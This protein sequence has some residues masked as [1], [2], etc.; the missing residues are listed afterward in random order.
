MCWCVG[1]GDGAEVQ[2]WSGQQ[3]LHRG[4]SYPAAPA[5][6]DDAQGPRVCVLGGGFGG[7]YTA[8]KLESLMW[9]KGNKPQV[10]AWRGWVH[11]GGL[12]HSLL[13]A[14]RTAV[15]WEMPTAS[16]SPCSLIG[17]ASACWA[18][19]H[20]QQADEKPAAT[21]ALTFALRRSR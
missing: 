14:V 17:A 12:L 1:G 18:S 7:L 8:V 16:Q 11:G 15:L 3:R 20:S 2:A 9:P 10:G 6:V 5:G 21:T 13:C 4:K 19:L